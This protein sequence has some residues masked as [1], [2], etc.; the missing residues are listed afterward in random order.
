MIHR[1]RQEGGI[2]ISWGAKLSPLGTGGDRAPSSGSS[3]GGNE[4]SGE[5]NGVLQRGKIGI[6]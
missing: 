4:T 1:P 3:G 6:H 2:Q 5:E